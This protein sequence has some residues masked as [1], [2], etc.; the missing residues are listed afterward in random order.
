[1]GELG[2]DP[3][4]DLIGG[5]SYGLIF[6]T[7][8]S[9][10]GGRPSVLELEEMLYR[11]SQAR[12]LEAGI[13]LLMRSAQPDFQEADGDKGE[14]Q[15]CRDL[16]LKPEGQGGMKT[17]MGQLIGLMSGAFA[18]RQAFFE[19]VW[20]RWGS[21]MVISDIAFRRASTCRLQMDGSFT[22]AGYLAGQGYK[23]NIQIPPSKAF[24]FVP[25]TSSINPLQ[26]ESV[27]ESAVQDH[28]HKKKLRLLEALWLQKFGIPPLH[29]QSDAPDRQQLMKNILELQGGGV[30]A[31]NST[32]QVTPIVANTGGNFR[33]AI[34]YCDGQMAV[35]VHMQW[36][37]LGMNSRSGSYALSQDLSDFFEVAEQARRNDLA[38]AFTNGPAA[39]FVYFNFGPDAAYPKLVFPPISDATQKRAQELYIA[40]MTK[41]GVPMEPAVLRALEEKVLPYAGVDLSKIGR[42]DP[43]DY[44]TAGTDT[45]L[46]SAPSSADGAKAVN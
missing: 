44:A 33:Q 38:D 39:K 43:A 24:V 17:P 10:Y 26:G 32:D 13:T 12:A 37:I 46:P 18:R 16:F 40:V 6:S 15:A 29:V 36:L 8:G 14:A 4:Q 22:Q 5:S 19:L 34:Q 28:N 20:E 21:W 25:G 1:V 27:F 42:N 30:F 23:G 11:D 2:I 31:S 45:T 9:V 35:S 3:S 7:A 41:T